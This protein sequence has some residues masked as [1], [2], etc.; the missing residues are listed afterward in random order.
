VPER[1]EIPHKPFTT[2]SKKKDKRDETRMRWRSP[3][4]QQKSNEAHILVL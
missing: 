4:N 2:K 1:P 3:P